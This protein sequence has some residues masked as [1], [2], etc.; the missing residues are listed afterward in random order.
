MTKQFSIGTNQG[1]CE[2]ASRIGELEKLIAALRTEFAYMS[3]R[4]STLERLT[5]EHLKNEVNNG[6]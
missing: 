5:T 1:D 3:G 6:G 2:C 4:L